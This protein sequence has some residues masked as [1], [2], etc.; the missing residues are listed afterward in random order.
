MAKLYY[1]KVNINSNIFDV[2]AK[3]IT[4]QDIM[5][6]VF[7]ALDDKREYNKKEVNTFL[8]DQ[9]DTKT[10][11]RE[12]I[13][14]FS[15]LNKVEDINEK[16]ITGRLV[17]RTPTFGEEFDR[18]SRTSKKVVHKNNSISTLFYF[19]LETEIVTFYSR[20]KLGYNQFMEA[21]ES[22]LDI[23]LDKIGFKVML[24]KD[25]FSIQERM[26]MLHKV[27]RIKSTIIPPNVNEEEIRALLE[28]KSQGMKHAN[29]TRE[30]RILESH[31]KNEKGID[32]NSTEV[33][34]TL[35]L[36]E[37][38]SAYGYSKLEVDGET[39]DGTSLVYDS[40]ENSPY[41]TT[42]PDSKKENLEGFIEYVKKGITALLAK[43]T[44]DNLKK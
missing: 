11:E 13:Y 15:E 4:I 39:K 23:Y 2:Y 28:R 17:K 5:K 35:E 19:D 7:D 16:Y 42:I 20:Q 3:K 30:T 36:N 6:M 8:D 25:P 31:K 22:L 44:I 37:A 34:E 1:A 29:I 43:R 9:G 41:Q 38:Y 10:V 21:F 27:N 26:K 32:L 12:E 33:K 18:V 40:D 24:I 14:N